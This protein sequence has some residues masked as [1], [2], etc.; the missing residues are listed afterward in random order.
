MSD[1]QSTGLWNA[2]VVAFWIFVVFAVIDFIGFSQMFFQW[3]LHGRK[4]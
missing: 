3:V 4:G 1:R 2:V